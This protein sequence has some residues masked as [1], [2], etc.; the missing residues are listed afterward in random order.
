MKKINNSLRK[1]S[2]K[3]LS[4][5]HKAILSFCYLLFFSLANI[6]MAQT[7]QQPIWQN[8]DFALYADR[9]VQKNFV[10]QALSSTE[11]T[12]N[13]KSPVN[14]LI[15][16][17]ITFKF[18]INGK[19]NEMK[20]GNDHHFNCISENG[21]CETPLIRF[22]RQFVDTKA[23]ADNSYLKPKTT[24]TLKMDMR[25]V[26]DA[27]AKNG[28]YTVFN[29]DKIYKQDFKGVYVAGSP[30]PLSW[31]FD[32]LVNNPLSKME[33]K[34]GDGIYEKV[35]ILNNPTDE[36]ATSSNWK[37]SK[38]VT[39]FPQYRSEYPLADALYNLSL[40]EA[41][42][43]VERDSTFRTG[44][45]WAGVWTRDI[46]Y[47]IILSMAH[48]QPKVARNSLLRK[49]KN[50]KIIQDTGTGGAYPASTDRIIWA[51]AAWEL[52][53]VTGDK[54]W[55]QQAYAIIKNSIDDDLEN[56]YDA[57]T[58]LVK[59]ESSFLDWREQTYPKWMQ[60]VDI[61]ESECLG[62]NAVH[63]QAN[64]VVAT[65]AKLLGHQQEAQKYQ[66]VADH[67]KQG[68]NRYLWMPEK[69]YYGQYLY[70][71]IAKIVSPR[72]EALGEALAVWFGIADG[73]K[74]KAVIGKTPV[75]SFGIPCIYPQIPN[76]PPYHND[77]VWPFVQSYYALAAAM[78]GNEEAVMESIACIYR[79]AA[80][81]ITNKENFVAS[82]GDFAG[83]QINSSNMLWSLSGSLG[84]IH[85]VIFG[86]R[87]GADDL[88]FHPFVPY[89]LRGK[90]SLTNFTYRNAVLD[91]E[92]EGYG[93]QV[94][95]FT[96]DG[97]ASSTTIPGNL[98]GHHSIKISLANNRL[99]NDKINTVEH[100]TTLDA[101]AVNY[102]NDN[103][104]SWNMI[105]GAKEYK[106]IKNGKELAKTTK[107]ELTVKESDYA[108]Y[109]VI[110]I[111]IKGMESFA[112]EPLLV[113][114]K[115]IM[116]TYEI[117][118]GI[119]K[120]PLPYKGASGA[121]FVEI[122]KTVN[123][124]LVFPVTI[125]EDG[126]YGIYFRYA[127]GNGPTNTENKCAIRT[128]KDGTNVLGTLVLPQR[129]KEEWSNWGLSNIIQ[130]T[131]KKGKHNLVVSFEP[132]NENMNGE[133]N[134]AMLDC[135]R[136]V[137]MK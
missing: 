15:S 47:S 90:R 127:N 55:L 77:A 104:L 81:W 103:L 48:L 25:E 6:A 117:E 30:A 115:S 137:K 38:S 110:A 86:I 87:F 57:K 125:A 128:V 40:E 94:K 66:Q 136:I 51:V 101:P 28:F 124:T 32:N 92:M 109:Q 49:V 99:S 93:N 126:E 112:S 135:M 56:A 41:Q 39:Q 11:L 69:S 46:S 88:S 80:L 84:M 24:F 62:T 8:N 75:M 85:K 2:Q 53:K 67:I 108:E 72:S 111:D 65:M 42:N 123:K 36:K 27:F 37:L 12:S 45:E 17:V 7:G 102:L 18:S 133:I 83:T 26:L 129:G 118:A 73:E 60:P 76:I 120:S 97:K 16:P 78:V 106:V 100:Y 14:K 64:I 68:I 22:G 82:N 96:I 131:L 13:Y 4:L 91:I 107:T 130:A 43:A 34:D 89:P 9:I 33:D 44:K 105:T 1:F 20:S 114:N 116:S 10:G 134:Q 63:Y 35:L 74:A 121:G 54:D 23:V 5:N 59:G 52:Y 95:S 50:G 79:P 122:S 98:Q 61:Y 19:D 132:H 29:G 70:G 3:R 119:E 58:G 113:A 71:R 21:S 31:D